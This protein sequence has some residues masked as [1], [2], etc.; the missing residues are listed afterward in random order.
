MGRLAACPAPDNWLENSCQRAAWDETPCHANFW[1]AGSVQWRES[2]ERSLERS[3]SIEPYL[4]MSPQQILCHECV[5]MV[6]MCFLRWYTC[7]Y[8]CSHFHLLCKKARIYW[9]FMADDR[10]FASHKH[11]SNSILQIEILSLVI[12]THFVIHDWVQSHVGSMCRKSN[13]STTVNYLNH[14]HCHTKIYMYHRLNN[15]CIETLLL[16]FS[17]LQ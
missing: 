16:T 8:K 3:E 1:L 5:C 17:Y 6:R 12:A 14:E 13:Y 11:L 15:R 2:S 10:T 4:Q 9:A 7:M